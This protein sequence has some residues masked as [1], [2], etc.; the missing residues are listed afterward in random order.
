[1]AEIN[2]YEIL[3]ENG[4]G[5]KRPKRDEVYPE[6]EELILRI[7]DD[8]V[9]EALTVYGVNNGFDRQLTA[10]IRGIAD[11]KNAVLG[12]RSL[13]RKK[14]VS[15]GEKYD[16]IRGRIPSEVLAD[17]PG[18][19]ED[20]RRWTTQTSG[21]LRQ[22]AS[23]NG[24]PIDASLER[25]ASLMLDMLEDT[26]GAV[27]DRTST[28][29]YRLAEEI[30]LE[31]KGFREAVL[32]IMEGCGSESVSVA[33]SR[34][35]RAGELVE[36][37]AAVK[38][39]DGGKGRT[40]VTGIIGVDPSCDQLSISFS[41][42]VGSPELMRT[43]A[44]K[45]RIN[46]GILNDL[47]AILAPTSGTRGA[48]PAEQ[49][50]ISLLRDRDRLIRRQN[51]SAV[52]D[53][54][55][56]ERIKNE[57]AFCD[58]ATDLTSLAKKAQAI[59][60]G[61]PNYNK[62]EYVSALGVVRARL[63]A[64]EKTKSEK[65][66]E[67]DVMVTVLEQRLLSLIDKTVEELG[68]FVKRLG[69]LGDDDAIS[70]ASVARDAIKKLEGYKAAIS[71]MHVPDTEEAAVLVK[72]IAEII[73]EI[74]AETP[75]FAASSLVRAELERLGATVSRIEGLKESGKKI[76]TE[77]PEIVPGGI[78]AFEQEKADE[79]TAA[80]FVVEKMSVNKEFFEAMRSR[81]ESILVKSF[82]NGDF[83]QDRIWSSLTAR[84][85][86]IADLIRSKEAEGAPEQI[87]DM[88]YDQFEE[89]KAGRD[90]REKTIVENMRSGMGVGV[91]ALEFQRIC[92]RFESVSTLFTA[93][94]FLPYTVRAQIMAETGMSDFREMFERYIIAANVGDS[95]TIEDIDAKIA[96]MRKVYDRHSTLRKE[97]ER[98]RLIENEKRRIEGEQTPVRRERPKIDAFG[99]KREEEKAE[100]RERPSLSGFGNMPAIEDDEEALKTEK[101][102]ARENSA[103]ES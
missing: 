39:A 71:G 2:I 100:R 11:I 98:R 76:K 55:L 92:D 44:T 66:R 89:A 49:E 4:V 12:N 70:S 1:M 93:E 18:Y 82:S 81:T 53:D 74:R 23:R 56:A 60:S 6:G 16:A 41:G 65:W 22:L 72:E 83:T 46:D 14:A 30:I 99:T 91:D 67:Q 97:Q 36:R 27:V 88:L 47:V 5:V 90:D 8:G 95:E 43:L 25:D 69:S 31:V 19:T 68:V 59:R 62:N 63:G 20:V 78:E 29:A 45:K 101:S 57:D 28:G 33:I 3:E 34:L 38:T 51:I 85:N 35:K 77:I 84:L 73:L 61:K 94:N 86:N 103:T 7:E 17:L 10:W 32:G 54:Y 24:T 42:C 87:I 96:A 26:L 37:W 79:L 13:S 9:L 50:L 75:K 21:L 102:G 15:L 52:G 80:I 58:F 48:L 40:R 64:W